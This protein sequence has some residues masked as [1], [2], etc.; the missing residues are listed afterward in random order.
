MLKSLERKKKGQANARQRKEAI[1]SETQIDRCYGL[2]P[3]NL[4]WSF[5]EVEAKRETWELSSLPSADQRK[6]PV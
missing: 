6:H 4:A 1:I 2:Y 3:E 5:F